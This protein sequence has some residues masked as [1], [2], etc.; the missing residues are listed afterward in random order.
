MPLIVSG[1]QTI[2]GK[3]KGGRTV[4]A[5]GLVGGPFIDNHKE[6]IRWLA[7]QV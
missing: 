4:G 3:K 1:K 7:M 5:T 2:A 6:G